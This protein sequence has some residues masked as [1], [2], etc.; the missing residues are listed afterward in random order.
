MEVTLGQIYAS[1][2][3]LNRI[4][5]QTL[6]IRLAYLFTRLIRELNTEYHALYKLRVVLVKNYGS[7]AEG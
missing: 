7:E 5:D 3:L 6:P 2:N 4:V 1:F